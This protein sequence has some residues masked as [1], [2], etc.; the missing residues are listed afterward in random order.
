[1]YSENM[2][3][4]FSV[5]R[6]VAVDMRGY[7]SSDKPSGVENYALPVL[8]ADVKNILVSLGKYSTKL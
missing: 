3:I 8:A 5:C 2:K 7:G 4:Y 6:V 1:M